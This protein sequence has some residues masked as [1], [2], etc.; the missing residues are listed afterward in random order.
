MVFTRNRFCW[1]CKLSGN[2]FLLRMM[3]CW[4]GRVRRCGRSWL[5]FRLPAFP[6]TSPFRYWTGSL[7]SCAT[8]CISEVRE[9]QFRTVMLGDPGFK[10]LRLSPWR[11]NL[12]T[13]WGREGNGMWGR[14]PA[15]RKQIYK[16]K[17]YPTLKVADPYPYCFGSWTLRIR[18]KVKIG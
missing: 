13:K 7:S 9:Y 2:W 1:C 12:H 17:T 10:T 4:L 18:I 14:G 5:S 3:S 11:L 6:P 8:I 15:Q 16:K